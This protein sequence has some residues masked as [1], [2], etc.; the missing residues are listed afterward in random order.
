MDD[1]EQVWVGQHAVIHTGVQEVWVVGKHVVNVGN[2]NN[3]NTMLDT[4]TEITHGKLNRN[5]K[6]LEI[7]NK[8]NKLNGNKGVENLFRY[9]ADNGDLVRNNIELETWNI[10]NLGRNSQSWK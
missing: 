6:M 3:Y 7:F 1:S 5:S 2:L 8:N 9:N 10:G 4:W